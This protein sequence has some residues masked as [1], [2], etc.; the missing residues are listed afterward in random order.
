MAQKNLAISYDP[1]ADVL[2]CF[3]GAPQEA[4]SEEVEG[5]VILRRDPDSREIVG[6]TVLDFLR[7][8]RTKPGDV[9]IPMHEQE[10][11]RA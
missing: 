11:M 5:G 6:F 10:E 9:I 1:K 2:Y 3:Y 7:H 4:I 8:F